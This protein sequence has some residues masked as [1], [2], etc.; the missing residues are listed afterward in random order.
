M[1]HAEWDAAEAMDYDALEEFE[2]AERLKQEKELAEAAE[3]ELGDLCH[4]D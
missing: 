2:V 3:E 1:T 4:E